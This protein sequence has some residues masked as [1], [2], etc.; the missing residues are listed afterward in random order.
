[1]LC[2][3]NI[4]FLFSVWGWFAA[5]ISS[6]EISKHDVLIDAFNKLI[7]TPK[8]RIFSIISNRT[9]TDTPSPPLDIDEWLLKRIEEGVTTFIHSFST[10]VFDRF[11]GDFFFLISS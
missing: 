2:D 11:S 5:S 9:M 6:I 1:M 8:K 10:I 4:L 3:I 7:L